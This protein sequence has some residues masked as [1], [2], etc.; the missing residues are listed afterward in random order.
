MLPS[1]AEI[2]TPRAY[3][4]Q[5]AKSILLQTA[6][7]SKIVSIQTL[8]DLTTL[9]APADEPSPFEHVA[10][11][12][13]LRDVLSAIASMPPRTRR[14][15]ELRRIEGLSQREIA[16][17]TGVS[18][19]T[20]EKHIGRG[21][22]MLTEKFGRGGKPPRGASQKESVETPVSS[23]HQ[24]SPLRNAGPRNRRRHR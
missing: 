13:D 19:N 2:G 21:I 4:F 18:E 20:V 23:G 3:A 15:F 6:R 1:V 10:G 12:N 24:E 5:V 14:V 17:I 11:R 16:R 22:R 8:A 9:E 7:R